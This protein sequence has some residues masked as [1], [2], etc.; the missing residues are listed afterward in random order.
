MRLTAYFILVYLA[1]GLQIGM[2]IS[3]A[4]AARAR[5]RTWCCS[6]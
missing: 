5:G 6:R 4:S 1:I 2:G 3:C